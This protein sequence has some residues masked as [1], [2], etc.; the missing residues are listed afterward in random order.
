MAPTVKFGSGS[1]MVWD[2]MSYRGIGILFNIDRGWNARGNI[3]I[4]EDSAVPL[5]HLL[6]DRAHISFQDDGVSCQ[7]ANSVK[8]RKSDIAFQCLD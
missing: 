6:G 1:V 3:W 4:L 2:A 8:E 7:R 5:A